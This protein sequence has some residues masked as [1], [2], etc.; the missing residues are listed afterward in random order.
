M[1]IRSITISLLISLAAAVTASAQTSYDDPMSQA[2]MKAFDEL[3][4]EDPRD[5]ETL[6][7]RAGLYYAHQDYIKALDDI[8]TAMKYYEP[9]DEEVR[10][11]AYQ[12]RAKIYQKQKKYDDALNDL[13]AVLVG[14]PSGHGQFGKLVENSATDRCAEHDTIA[15]V[16]SG[17]CHG[18]ER[19]FAVFHRGFFHPAHAQERPSSS[20]ITRVQRGQSVG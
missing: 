14:N 18:G 5:P 11:P 20:R 13:N 1:D 2:L 4:E 19:C 16:S 6:V 9:G 8:N 3:L 17:V 12:L 15:P 7:R 10:Y